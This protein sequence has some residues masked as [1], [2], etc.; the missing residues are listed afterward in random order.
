[1]ARYWLKD[2][3][4]YSMPILESHVEMR[5]KENMVD[6]DG[7]ITFI[8]AEEVHQFDIERLVE[9]TVLEL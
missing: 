8:F 5:L 2:P 1:M 4:S 7:E 9:G 3:F 6:E